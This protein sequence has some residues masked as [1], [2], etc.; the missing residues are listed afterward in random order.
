M[1][2]IDLGKDLNDTIVAAVN[3]KVSAEVFAALNTDE[4]IGNYIMSAMMQPIKIEQYGSKT[5][6]YL[7][8]VIR[9]AIQEATKKAI[10]EWMAD[11]EGVLKTKVREALTGN[12][13]QMAGALVEGAI[14]ATGRNYMT[15]VD[16][17]FQKERD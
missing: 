3:A 1:V 7:T 15:K 16:V 12:I 8:V 5:E 14:E 17:S 13:E 9:K 4:V 2:G 10:G 6:P 11:N